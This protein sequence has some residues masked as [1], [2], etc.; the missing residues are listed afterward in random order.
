MHLALLGTWL[1]LAGTL[2]G[3]AAAWLWA[4]EQ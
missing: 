3:L 4:E 1:V 2:A